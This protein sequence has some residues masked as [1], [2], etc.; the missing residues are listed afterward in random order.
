MKIM[1]VTT[2]IYRMLYRII[3]CGVHWMILKPV[4]TGN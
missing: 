4:L 2:T 1:K 3:V